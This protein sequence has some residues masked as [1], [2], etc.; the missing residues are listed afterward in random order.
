MPD[1]FLE[2]TPTATTAAQV[3]RGGDATV[4]VQAGNFNSATVKI[5]ASYDGGTTWVDLGADGSFT[6]NGVSNMNLA[7][8]ELRFNVA[9]GTPTTPTAFVRGIFDTTRFNQ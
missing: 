9:G 8:G 1:D 3:W 6:A 4:F 2:F 7:S 5:Q